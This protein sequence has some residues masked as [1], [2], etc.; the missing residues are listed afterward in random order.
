[1][2]FIKQAV[3]RG[4]MKYE[5]VKYEGGAFATL[6]F[7]QKGPSEFQFAKLSVNF[8]DKFYQYMRTPRDFKP[9]SGK[10]DQFVIL[11]HEP[12]WDVIAQY[13]LIQGLKIFLDANLKHK[14]RFLVEGYFED[15][16]EFIPTAPILKSLSDDASTTAQVFSLLREFM[17]DSPFA[18]RLLHDPKLPAVAIDSPEIIRK[19][20][21]Q[22]IPDFSRQREIL[23]SAHEKLM[24]F[25]EN[26]R[27]SAFS[28]LGMLSL[29]TNADT[30]ELKGQAII[31]FYSKLAEYCDNLSRSLRSLNA[32]QFA[33]ECSFLNKQREIHN[34]LVTV[35]RY[36]LER[37][38]VMAENIGK[39]FESEYA[40]RIPVAFIGNFHTSGIINRLPK[41][42]NYVVIEPRRQMLQREREEFNNALDLDTRESY[43]KKL[44]EK[45]KLQVAPLAKEQTYYRSYLASESAKIKSRQDDFI[46]SS[47]FGPV[48]NGKIIDFLESN[49]IL[50]G[51]QV[52][53]ADGGKLPPPPFNGAFA[54]FSYGEEGDGRSVG[55]SMVVYDQEESKWQEQDRLNYI[56][57]LLFIR[58]YEKS[59]NDTKKVSF[60]QDEVTNR[61]YFSVFDQQ[62][63]RFYLFESEE[64]MDIF[65][66]LFLP[67]IIIHLRL[68]IRELMNSERKK[69]H[70]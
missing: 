61:I 5:L 17:I 11:I 36:A 35:Y 63:K 12:H 32:Q 25:S 43:L 56:K 67:D 23:L 18:Y 39:H 68:S 1:V 57:Y 37:D 16:I 52:D 14:F 8:P 30:R 31:D 7:K 70:V 60:Y 21:R 42:I 10:T 2:D 41:D 9:H 48:T 40:D 22:S 26:Q 33:D 24:S 6:T 46:S 20:P 13:Q 65:D 53:F 54:S 55:A 27:A 50:L 64:G 49:G 4:L 45:L 47:P 62:S 69:I 29:F 58:P 28:S 66:S 3:P 38:A 44:A 19:T 34:T 15:E 59:R 51:A